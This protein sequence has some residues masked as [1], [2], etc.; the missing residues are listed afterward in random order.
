MPT[1]R[2]AYAGELQFFRSFYCLAIAVIVTARIRHHL[3]FVRA[4]GP[5]RRRPRLLGIVAMP[6]LAELGVGVAGWVLI[7]SLIAGAAY[8]SAA[9]LAVAA[10]SS[11]FYFAQIIDLPEIRRKAN[12]VPVILGLLAV[13]GSVQA[14]DSPIESAALL[15]VE[16]V[17]VQI[18]FSAGLTKLRTSGL[19]WADGRTLRSWLLHYHLRDGNR[20]ALALASRGGVC[21]VA[22][23]SILLF[24]LTFWMVIPFPKLTVPYLL[25]ASA[26]HLATATL[27]RIHYWLFLGPAY[28]VFVPLLFRQ[29]ATLLYG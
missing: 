17:I 11:L 3:R 8:V 6:R 23:V 9:A 28:L 29:T 26:F 4:R 27:M 18:Y 24:E 20:A 19:A 10:L 22:A 21:R 2:A 7:G 14:V 5:A 1:L 16:L 13:S 15:L 25:A 12:T